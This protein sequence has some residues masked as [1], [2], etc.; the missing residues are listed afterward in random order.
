M[1]FKTRDGKAAIIAP[2][3]V[4]GITHQKWC[5]GERSGVEVV[6][7]FKGEQYLYLDE[8]FEKV[9]EYC[10]NA[11]ALSS[12][13]GRA[14]VPWFAGEPLPI[15][16]EKKQYL[17]EPIVEAHIGYIVDCARCDTFTDI[18]QV[19]KRNAAVCKRIA[20]YLVGL[21]SCGADTI[22]PVSEHYDFIQLLWQH[23]ENNYQHL[24]YGGD[25]E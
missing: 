7:M 21:T 22:N 8:P 10:M 11:S 6:V 23:Y 16:K 9:Y 24:L 19:I 3:R 14:K 17:P 5:D 12:E 18:K 13:H 1:I 2:S 25:P 20:N 4:L 15:Q